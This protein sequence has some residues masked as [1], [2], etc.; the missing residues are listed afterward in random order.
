MVVARWVPLLCIAGF[1]LTRS[2][3]AEHQQSCQG[4]AYSL[5]DAYK[6]VCSSTWQFEARCTGEKDMW[7]S[8][9]VPNQSDP[10]VRPWLDQPIIIVGYE[11]TRIRR[12]A[13]WLRR[14][15]DYLRGKPQDLDQSWFMIGSAMQPDPMLYLA[16]GENHA[17]QML[18]TSLGDPWPAKKDANPAKYADMLDLHGICFGGGSITIFLTLYYAPATGLDE[19]SR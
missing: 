13:F 11:L 7:D 15:W 14:A 16:P 17:R 2:A 4:R 1:I 5:P 3:M 10:F 8:W 19:A 18:P 6:V 9:S 12:P